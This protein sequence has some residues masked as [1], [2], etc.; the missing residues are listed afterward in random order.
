MGVNVSKIRSA[1]QS[2]NPLVF[3]TYTFPRQ[4]ETYIDN[5]IKVFLTEIGQGQLTEVFAYCLRELVTNAKKAHAKRIYFEQKRLS[6]TK[7]ADYKEG[8]A[9]FKSEMLENAA[10]YLEQQKE[11][12]MYIKI[13]LEAK[14]NIVTLEV[15]NKAELSVF[16]Y[17][18]VHDRITRIMQFD[19]AEEGFANLLDESEGAGF[20][21]ATLILILRKLGLSEENYQILS[22][23][24]ETISRLTVP[25][26]EESQRQIFYLS[27]KL[28][29]LINGLPEFPENI[30]AINRL[31][32]KPDCK[33]SDIAM[34]ISNEVALT[35]ELLKLVNSAAFSLA[36]PCSSI[37][38]AVKLAGIRGIRNL[39]FSIGSMQSLTA[40]SD[41]RK[42]ALWNHSHCVAFY[43]YNLARAFFKGEANREL[44]DDSYVCGLLHDMG[45][46]VFESAH[47]AIYEKLTKLCEEQGV[48]QEFFEQMVAGANH[49]EIGARVAEKW[50]FPSIIVDVIQYHHEPERAPESSWKLVALINFADQLVHYREGTVEFAQFKPSVL[51]LFTITSEGQVRQ[52]SE[53]LSQHF[54]NGGAY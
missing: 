12:R 10:Y 28:I 41:E 15:R 45:K 4:A 18:R 38:D 36:T 39:L 17:K 21:L 13:L 30:N 7:A 43:A 42:K 20:G 6:L 9:H 8:M 40:A 31:I 29:E 51:S 47:P 32:S 5:V 1:I 54:Q 22:E 14:N 48:S 37:G 33:M 27:K 2:G 34:K 49:G 19:S 11:R 35:G 25:Y 53:Q 52:L 50:H 46:I 23:N 3:I 44:V 16:E 24:G 26:S